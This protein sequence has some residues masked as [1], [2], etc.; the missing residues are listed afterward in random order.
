MA[1]LEMRKI[2]ICALKKDRKKILEF[3]QRK[4][5]LEIHE[6]EN[7]RIISQIIFWTDF[8]NNSFVY[9]KSQNSQQFLLLLFAQL[10]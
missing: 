9:H 10:S 6:T 5:C 1:V 8:L 2:N 4:G 3:L 7:N